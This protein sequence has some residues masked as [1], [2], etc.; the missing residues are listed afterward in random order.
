MS[1]ILR[2]ARYHTG[3]RVALSHVARSLCFAFIFCPYLED[4]TQ[5]TNCPVSFAVY[6][7]NVLAHTTIPG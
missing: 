1:S 3:L 6:V 7:G 5:T 2:K 4:L